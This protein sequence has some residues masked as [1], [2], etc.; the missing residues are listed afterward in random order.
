[1]SNVK[2]LWTAALLLLCMSVMAVCAAATSWSE[3]GTEPKPIPVG[4]VWDQSYAGQIYAGNTG[5]DAWPTSYCIK[6]VD[7][8]TTLTPADRWG[9]TSFPLLTAGAASMPVDFYLTLVA[10]PI[11]PLTYPGTDPVAPTTQAAAGSLP[12]YW[13]LSNGTIALVTNPLGRNTAVGRFSDLLAPDGDYC[14][15]QV[16]QLAGMF[17]NKIVGG[18]ADG[19]YKPTGAV[20]RATMAVFLKRALNLP[21]VAYQGL[22]SDVLEDT[23]WAWAEIEALK[24]AGLVNGY[25]DGRYGPNDGV[26]RDTMAVYVARALVGG[27]VMPTTPVKATFSDVPTSYWAFSEIEY[28]HSQSIVNGYSDGTGRYGPVDPV[29]RGTMALFIYRAFVQ[30]TANTIVLAGP[31]TSKIDPTTTTPGVSTV[32]TDPGFAYVG[33]EGIRLLGTSITVDLAAVSGG[34]ST[35]LGSVVVDGTTATAAS[36]II[37]AKV[38]IPTDLAPGSY[39]LEASIGGQALPHSQAFTVSAPPTPPSL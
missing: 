26:N 5:A 12:D 37:Y 19:T 11:S 34:T 21:T 2:F 9:S 32:T 16:E 14:R 20:D 30:Q 7:P 1:M 24:T 29:I 10:P 18:Y 27:Q 35:S 6:S 3:L 39:T 38:A 4:L 33:F 17:P 25:G 13:I 15:A 22:F 23:C 28:C 36:P 31:A 8:G